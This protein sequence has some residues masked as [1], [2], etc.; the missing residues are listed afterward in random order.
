MIM[1]DIL[2]LIIRCYEIDW[3]SRIIY[4]EE[5]YVVLDKPAGTSVC[6]QSYFMNSV[7]LLIPIYDSYRIVSKYWIVDNNVK[8]C[9]FRIK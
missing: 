9:H 6:N 2:N 4:V 1:F 8:S 3:R 7:K 5:S